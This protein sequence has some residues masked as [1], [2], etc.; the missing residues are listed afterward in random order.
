MLLAVDTSTMKMGLALYDGTQ[1]LG[2]LLWKSQHHHTVELAP[3][4]DRL[5]RGSGLKMD[6]VRA[7]GIA[8]GPGSFTSLRVGLAFVKGLALAKHIPVLG[9]PTLDVQA[10]SVEVENNPLV[11][12]L[13][14][15]R[16]RLAVGWYKPTKNGWQA[17]G[18]VAVTTV[19]EL[20]KKIRKPTIVCGELNADERKRLERKRAN[21][22]LCSPAG[23]V[24]R[25][26]VLAEL[27]W[28]RW[29][30]GESDDIASLA[31]IYLHIGDPIPS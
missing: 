5:L 14:A 10:A 17:K 15:G 21:V 6:D 25:P 7:V 9:I 23:S 20:A 12:V 19:N 22:L 29:Q 3:T 8:L 13:Q 27:A 4:V 2:E 26:G 24:R 11:A 30:A 31:P 1:V 18:P 28:K 16:G